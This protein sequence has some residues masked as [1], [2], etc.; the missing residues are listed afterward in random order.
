LSVPFLI[1]LYVCNFLVVSV[2]LSLISSLLDCQFLT[3]LPSP[4]FTS[5]VYSIFLFFSAVIMHALISFFFIRLYEN[6]KR[7]IHLYPIALCPM[8]LLFCIYSAKYPLDVI[9]F[10]PGN[11]HL[12]IRISQL[13]LFGLSIRVL[14]REKQWRISCVHT[15]E[16]QVVLCYCAPSDSAGGEWHIMETKS[17]SNGGVCHDIHKKSARKERAI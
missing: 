16:W 10:F 1:I 12:L 14:F 3:V 17:S 8:N 11:P 2:L 15:D 9:R 5:V 6:I 4:L 7:N 13:C